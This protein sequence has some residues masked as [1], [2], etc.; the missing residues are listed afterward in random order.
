MSRPSTATGG[1]GGVLAGLVTLAGLL[2]ARSLF[3]WVGRGLK[4][5]RPP[6]VDRHSVEMGH[7]TKDVSP[8][9]VIFAVVLVVVGATLAMIV[10]TS[11]QS[12]RVDRPLSLTSPP[13]LATPA[14]PPPP[15]APRL[16]EVPGEQLR[17]FHAA[18]DQILNGTGW[19]DRSAGVAHIPIDRAEDLLLQQGLPA[20]SAEEA[21]RYQNQA[22]PSDASSGRT[23]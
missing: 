22:R 9:V 6:R 21:A 11:F 7:E 5:G 23:P 15:P 20:R 1:I 2:T 13:S 4:G 3:R 17:Q 16:E 14:I 19:V 12:G 18:E 10:V 8:L